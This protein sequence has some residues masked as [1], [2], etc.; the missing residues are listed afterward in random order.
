MVKLFHI[1]VTLLTFLTWDSIYG[2]S[3]YSDCTNL[4]EIKDSVFHAKNINGFGTKKEFQNNFNDNLTT[5]P[6]ETNSI[7]YLI[8]IPATG[9]FTFDILADNPSDDW[10]FLLY[11][12]KNLFCKRIDSNRIK[13][14]RTNLS[15]SSNTGLSLT[16]TKN[17]S[18]PGIN[19]N[20][21]KYVDVVEGNEYVLVVNNPKQSGS[22]HKLILHLPQKTETKKVEEPL[23]T[24]LPKLKFSLD[25]KDAITHQA[26]S[27][28]VSLTGLLKENIEMQDITHYQVLI[29]K[30]TYRTNL[31]VAAPNYMLYTAK[32]N[33]KKS[34]DVFTETILL[35]KIEVGKKVSL[36]DIQFQP[37][38]DKFLPT[39]KSSL[40]SLLFFMQQ[41]KTVGIEI[42]GHVNGPGEPNHKD[43]ITLSMNRSI[44]VKRY[45]LENG[46]NEERLVCSGFG[47]SKMI[48][49]QPSTDEEHSMNRRVE[50]KIL[51]Q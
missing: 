41:N 14:I 19:N 3:Q 30:G 47:N 15:R 42:E 20:Y 25:I 43:F 46:I 13:P 1:L 29:E 22:G 39:A 44:A 26:V 24:E 40:K 2:Q 35:E 28:N 21:S 37:A 8:K 48:Y 50:I 23:K 11:E 12:Y 6:S 16:E 32:F 33:I 38:S 4:L 10:D 27:S 49:P 9:K 5:F 17:F 7:W 34:A 36:E 45:L 18:M 31:L 51:K